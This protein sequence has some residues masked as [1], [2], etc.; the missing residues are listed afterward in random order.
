MKLPAEILITDLYPV[1]PVRADHQIDATEAVVPNGEV[2]IA[3]IHNFGIDQHPGPVGLYLHDGERRADLGCGYPPPDPVPH[4]QVPEGL[5]EIIDDD[6]NG[7]RA[8]VGNSYA[9]RP[10]C[11]VPE[12]ADTMDGHLS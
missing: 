4:L 12:Q 7:R 11:G 8:R 2:F 9:S 10:E 1:R 3:D 5:L 6:T